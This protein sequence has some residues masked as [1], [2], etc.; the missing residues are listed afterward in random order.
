MEPHD[1]SVEP[2]A[3]AAEL[4]E[5]MQYLERV[6]LNTGS[7]GNASCRGVAQQ[8]WITPSGVVP[9]TLTSA[10]IVA[11]PLGGAVASTTRS[12]SSEW[13][14]H[15]DIY[16][17]RPDIGAIV[18]THSCYATALACIR[19]PIPAF[20]YMVAIAGGDSIR[21]APYATFG[22][23]QLSDYAVS[24]LSGR[25]ACLLAN[26]GVLALGPSPLDAAKLALEVEQLA[27]QYCIA[28]R[29]GDPVTLGDD[30]MRDVLGKFASYGQRNG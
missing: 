15:H 3:G 5:V 19:K 1:L 18:H 11:M 27:K 30:Q 12:P 16:M 20:H 7:A 21:C 9:T 10:S 2:S 23:Q 17:A 13:R 25:T 28:I 24:A 29:S 6:G 8:Y 14:M 4:V 22:T 26:H